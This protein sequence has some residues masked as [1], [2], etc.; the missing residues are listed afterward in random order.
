V[1]LP[2]HTAPT[3]K[4]AWPEA[5]IDA[6]GHDPHSTYVEM[7]WLEILGPSRVAGTPE[8]RPCYLGEVRRKTRFE[9]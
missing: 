5:V 4:T 2:D 3:L 6:V 9:P 7:F 1:P 8:A